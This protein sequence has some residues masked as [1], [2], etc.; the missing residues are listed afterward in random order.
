MKRTE[1]SKEELP[2]VGRYTYTITLVVL[3][4]LAWQPFP[5]PGDLLCSIS[6]QPC[7]STTTPHTAIPPIRLV[8]QR[9]PP[10]DHH[11]A[12]AN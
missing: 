10:D 11:F 9:P 1:N 7:R 8:G 2:V 5:T 3:T 6:N 12:R 4:L